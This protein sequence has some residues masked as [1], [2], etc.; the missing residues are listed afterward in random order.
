MEVIEGSSVISM[1]LP[2]STSREIDFDADCEKIAAA[3]ALPLSICFTI[4][5]L[6]IWVIK[7]TR[8]LSI[9]RMY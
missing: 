2:E 3:V 7:L 8:A 9:E 4:C 1:P 6:A 5:D